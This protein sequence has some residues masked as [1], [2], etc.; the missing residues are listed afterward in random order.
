MTVSALEN[1]GDRMS[2]TCFFYAACDQSSGQ[3]F[4]SLALKVDFLLPIF[5]SPMPSQGAYRIKVLE[6]ASL[7]PFVRSSV[8]F[9]I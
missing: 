7:H 9:Q 1:T 3:K 2:Q 4:L 6:P 8:Y 5:S